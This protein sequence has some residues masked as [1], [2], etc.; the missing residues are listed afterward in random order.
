MENIKLSSRNKPRHH[1]SSIGNLHVLLPSHRQTPHHSHRQ[2]L[3]L[4]IS[5]NV[6][7]LLDLA[8]FGCLFIGNHPHRQLPSRPITVAPSCR[9]ILYR[10]LGTCPTTVSTLVLEHQPEKTLSP[11]LHYPRVCA[12]ESI[13]YGLVDHL[14]YCLISTF[15]DEASLYLCLMW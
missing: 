3:T 5:T 9:S 8:T 6:S 10:L 7:P 14:Q 1:H 13:L 11:K 4:T 15:L 12:R 2:R